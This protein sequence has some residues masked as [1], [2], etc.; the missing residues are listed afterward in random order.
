MQHL[1][2]RDLLDEKYATHTT[3]YVASLNAN[4]PKLHFL[5]PFQPSPTVPFNFDF[6]IPQ[7]ISLRLLM[8]R[9]ITL[10]LLT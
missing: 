8:I 1:Q 4:R 3:G 6:N 5:L 9:P 2:A 10:S 7:S